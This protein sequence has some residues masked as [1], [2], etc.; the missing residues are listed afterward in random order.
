MTPAEDRDH[1]A[2]EA[3]EAA[4]ETCDARAFPLKCR[5][6]TVVRLI[7]GNRAAEE[8]GRIDQFVSSMSAF[9]RQ[10]L[11]KSATPVG[12]REYLDF[13]ADQILPWENKYAEVVAAIVNGLNDNPK[14]AEV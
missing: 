7:D 2:R 1:E 3:D 10:A 4:S 5:T 11:L 8:F 14:S 6:N 12:D 9:D 13:I